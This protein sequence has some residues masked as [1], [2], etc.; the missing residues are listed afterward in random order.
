MR[1]CCRAVPPPGAPTAKHRGGP[2]LRFAWDA[3]ASGRSGLL[4]SLPSPKS[5][6]CSHRLRVTAPQP[7][8]TMHPAAAPLRGHAQTQ[9]F[10][11]RPTH[12]HSSAHRQPRPVQALLPC[13]GRPCARPLA[14]LPPPHLL[15]APHQP[16][17]RPTPTIVYCI[18]ACVPGTPAPPAPP[19]ATARTCVARSLWSRIPPPVCP[20]PTLQILERRAGCT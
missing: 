8:C 10:I 17:G 18:A 12:T 6:S 20:P 2:W 7:R 13:G 9:N 4:P 3:A 16:G 11:A 15:L 14:S 5:F 19:P 1:C